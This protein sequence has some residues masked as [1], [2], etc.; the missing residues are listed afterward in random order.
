MKGWSFAHFCPSDGLKTLRKRV[1]RVK[2]KGLLQPK[3]KMNSSLTDTGV[4]LMLYTH[5]SF[6]TTKG[7]LKKKNPARGH[8]YTGSG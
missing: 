8:P 2:V 3:M 7:E 4:F 6:L 5:L 1:F